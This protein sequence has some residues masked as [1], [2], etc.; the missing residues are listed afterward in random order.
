M[1]PHGVRTAPG[2]LSPSGIEEEYVV[3]EPVA[4]AVILREVHRVVQEVACLYH[5]LLGMC[6]APPDVPAVVFHGT[7][8]GD[9]AVQ[10][11]IRPEKVVGTFLEI[12][13]RGACASIVAEVRLIEH[14]IEIIMRIVKLEL[15]VGIF[16]KYHDSLLV[17]YGWES[18]TGEQAGAALEPLS[19]CLLLCPGGTRAPKRLVACRRH[20]RGLH[21]KRLFQTRHVH[22]HEELTGFPATLRRGRC[23]YAGIHDLS[24]G[25]HPSVIETVML[26]Q[27]QIAILAQVIM[28]E[29]VADKTHLDCAAVRLCHCHQAG[30]GRFRIGTKDACPQRRTQQKSL[31]KMFHAGIS[32]IDC[33]TYAGKCNNFTPP[34]K[35]NAIKIKIIVNFS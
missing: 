5:H 2:S 13:L 30:S 19:G 3:Y 26:L 10:V 33:W 9:R 14:A 29:L 27:E 6:V 35:K 21:V 17:A 12:F 15:H 18:R 16:H 28:I 7:G 32:T 24:G 4:V 8:E 22:I 20:G 25:I 11:E 31:K 1:R 23:P 34:T